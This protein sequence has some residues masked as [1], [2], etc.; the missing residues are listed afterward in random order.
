MVMCE[1]VLGSYP[2]RCDIYRRWDLSTSRDVIIAEML[3][4][5]RWEAANCSEDSMPI[6]GL[7]VGNFVCLPQEGI[8]AR[9]YTLSAPESSEFV[10]WRVLLKCNRGYF[11]FEFHHS[12]SEPLKYLHTLRRQRLG[13]HLCICPTAAFAH[14]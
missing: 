12:G 13:F 11:I 2:F 9:K 1:E 3:D 8:W 14:I 7:H 5:L 4:V 6:A 10:F